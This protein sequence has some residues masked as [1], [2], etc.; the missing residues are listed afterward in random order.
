MSNFR[1]L[2]FL[3]LAAGAQ[4]QTSMQGA[5]TDPSGASVAR[6][7]VEILHVETST[8]TNLTTD[9]TG[10]WRQPALSPGDYQVKI[11]AHGFQT[12]I[13]KGI[14]L[15]VGQDAVLDVRR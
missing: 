10:H 6:A 5:V 13:R 12:V 8:A 7:A 9:D 4:G 3:L 11:S 15:T 1:I 2:V 14:H